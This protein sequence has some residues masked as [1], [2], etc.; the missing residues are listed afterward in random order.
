MILLGMGVDVYKYEIPTRFDPEF[1]FSDASPPHNLFA[2]IGVGFGIFG[3]PLFVSL[4][5]EITKEKFAGLR[6]GYHPLVH[7][8]GALM[9]SYILISMAH[10]WMFARPIAELFWVFAGYVYNNEKIITV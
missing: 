4:F 10:P 1:F 7:G 6:R 3:I 8:V 5:Y 2:E 9:I